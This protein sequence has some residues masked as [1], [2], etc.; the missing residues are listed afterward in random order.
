[1]KTIFSIKGG[2]EERLHHMRGRRTETKPVDGPGARQGLVTIALRTFNNSER[3][4]NKYPLEE[5]NHLLLVSQLLSSN[6]VFGAKVVSLP[7]QHTL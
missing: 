2:G 7:Q 4:C 1:M 6:I 5:F 3:R